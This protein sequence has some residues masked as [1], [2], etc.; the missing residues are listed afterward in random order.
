MSLNGVA[1]VRMPTPSL[2]SSDPITMPP[3][4]VVAPVMNPPVELNCA[5]PLLAAQF[6]SVVAGVLL[7]E[8][9]FSS[10]SAPFTTPSR[11]ARTGM[12]C[13][14]DGE[15]RRASVFVP[16]HWIGSTGVSSR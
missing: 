4:T 3:P 13:H 16:F 9:K 12:P 7:N 14:T 5:H 10:I 8:V 1:S 2:S 15:Y 11:S 6:P